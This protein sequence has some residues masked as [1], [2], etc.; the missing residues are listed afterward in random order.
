M[1]K[2]EKKNDANRDSVGVVKRKWCNMKHDQ[3]P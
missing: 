1:P 2:S 3:N